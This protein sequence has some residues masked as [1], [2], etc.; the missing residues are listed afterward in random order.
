MKAIINKNSNLRWAVLFII[1]SVFAFLLPVCLNQFGY[2]NDYRI[3]EYPHVGLANLFLGYPE[4]QHLW[5]IGRPIG[6]ILL[7]LQ[8]FPIFSMRALAI[9]Q[10]ANVTLIACLAVSCFYFFVRNIRISTFFAASLSILMMALPAMTINSFWVANLV[11]SLIPLFLALLAQVLMEQAKPRLLYVISLLMCGFLIYPPATFF[12]I[13]ITLVKFLFA[14]QKKQLS[15]STL[16][17]EIKVMLGCSLGFFIFLKLYK[18]ALIK[19]HFL[20][21]DWRTYYKTIQQMFPQYQLTLG[22]DIHAKLIQM[23]QV[24]SLILSSWLPPLPSLY[25]AGIAI[26]LI[27]MLAWVL[28]YNVYLSQPQILNAF[29][30]KHAKTMLIGFGIV[31]GI[32]ALAMLPIIA[33]PAAYDITYRAIFPV[34]SLIPIILVCF[35]H[36][37]WVSTNV[38]NLLKHLGLLLF[39]LFVIGMMYISWQRVNL[40]VNRSAT[41]YHKI[42]SVLSKRMTNQTQEI[43]I[44]RPI[45][46]EADLAWLNGD[47]SLDAT[48]YQ[49]EGIIRAIL[50]ELG[51]NPAHYHFAFGNHFSDSSVAVMVPHTTQ[52]PIYHNMLAKTLVGPWFY[53]GKKVSIHLE[54]NS[55]VLTNEYQLSSQAVIEQES[56]LDATDWN[57]KATLS[58]NGKELHWDNGTKWIR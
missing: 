19:T 7:N 15:L 36:Q 32:G 45:I 29:Q 48:S 18:I 33:G 39:T 42:A 2:H 44:Q 46:P 8:L 56:F 3:W 30:T 38:P 57:T 58:L 43:R 23:T 14:P 41:E 17:M 54:N 50:I 12:F 35:M 5:G 16:W 24:F 13:T 34:S 28:K 51:Y 25:L 26:T 11:P 27:I 37:L 47:F 1:T 21:F 9:N 31:F 52:V 6:A 4:S 10:M 55:L 22:T 20:G 40:V 49:I 53:L